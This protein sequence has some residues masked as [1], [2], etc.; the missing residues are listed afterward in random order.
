MKTEITDV[1]DVLQLLLN[2]KV[3]DPLT[4]LMDWISDQHLR[5]IA[6]QEDREGSEK[7][8]CAEENYTLENCMKVK[9]FEFV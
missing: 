7:P 6:V 3:Y 8:Q 1:V 4:I 2:S 5:K 9:A